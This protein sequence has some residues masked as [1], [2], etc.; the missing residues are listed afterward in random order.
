MC[1]AALVVV[2]VASVHTSAGVC[3]KFPAYSTWFVFI[4]LQSRFNNAVSVFVGDFYQLKIPD[5]FN[6][7]ML[8]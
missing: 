5:L 6:F 3:D 8:W 7:I 4:H 1:G 2:A